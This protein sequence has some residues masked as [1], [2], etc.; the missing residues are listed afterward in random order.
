MGFIHEVRFLEEHDRTAGDHILDHNSVKWEDLEK[1][2][3][4]IFVTYKIVEKTR[5]NTVLAA[6]KIAFGFVF[7]HRMWMVTAEYTVI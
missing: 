4:G 6:A 1:I 7:I 3:D 2:I 5:F